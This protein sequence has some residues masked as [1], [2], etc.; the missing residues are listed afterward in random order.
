M[1]HDNTA[2]KRH[3]TVAIFSCQVPEY[4]SPAQSQFSGYYC[5]GSLLILWL[6]AYR[7]AAVIPAANFTGKI[8]LH[9]SSYT[10]KS[11]ILNL[12][13]KSLSQTSEDWCPV[14]SDNLALFPS[15]SGILLTRWQTPPSQSA[16]FPVH[17]A[18]KTKG[19]N[20]LIYRWEGIALGF[21]KHI[22][23]WARILPSDYQSSFSLSW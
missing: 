15:L 5:T 13:T 7:F 17:L 6:S 22:Q 19:G 3:I 16:A 11:L 4:G 1:C 23:I 18:A 21:L 14:V 2:F 20:A 10:A 8:K 9:S 12:P